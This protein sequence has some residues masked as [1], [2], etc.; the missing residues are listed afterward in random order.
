DEAAVVLVLHH[1]LADGIAAL[2]ILSDL[3]G[4]ASAGEAGF[5]RPLPGWAAL[6]ADNLT[7][8]LRGLARLPQRAARLV[9]GVAVLRTPTARAAPTSLN[10]PTGGRRRMAT[11]HCPL[12]EALAVARAHGATIN[13]LVLVVIAEALG[14]LAAARGERLP[15]VVVSVPVSSRRATS[16]T[17]LGNQTGV[18]PVSVPASGDRVV[19]LR[20]V[21]AVTRRAKALPAAASTALLGP[22][23][24]WLARLG[25]FRWFTDHQRLVHTFATN[26]RG[27]A[28]R[29]RLGGL[30]ATGL[31]PMSVTTGN[32]A[33]AFAT[34]SYAGD[35]GITIMADPEALPELDRLRDGLDT[36]L[37]GFLAIRP[38]AA[39][40][41]LG[42]PGGGGPER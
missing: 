40:G 3:A 34:L 13:D 20:T 35:L 41:A 1:V 42:A 28:Q 21:A 15:S 5:P 26:L 23:F 36:A 18:M 25:L 10:R 27:P 37:R 31:V 4:P 30:E 9:A 8:R 16:G 17:D 24:R 29:L 14:G 33:A 7:G 11:V 19:R 32:I 22:W 12:D 39:P 2:A 6:L 38:V